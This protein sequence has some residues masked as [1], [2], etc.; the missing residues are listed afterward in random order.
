M[1]KDIESAIQTL[2]SNG[3][4]EFEIRTAW[5]ST[6][7]TMTRNALVRSGS[8]DKLDIK[9]AMRKGDFSVNGLGNKGIKELTALILKEN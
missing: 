3:Y 4:D 2:V 5:M 6:L 1:S 7:S 9:D 8:Y